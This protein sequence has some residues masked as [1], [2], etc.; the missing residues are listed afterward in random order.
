MKDDQIEDFE[1]HN[2]FGKP[3][4]QWIQDIVTKDYWLKRVAKSILPHSVQEFLYHT[5][6]ASNL[7]PYPEMDQELRLELTEEF[8]EEIRNL[9]DITGRDLS[10]WKRPR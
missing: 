4:Y 3:R 1:T 6:K 5:A 8:K 9:E 10:H 7:E 2:K